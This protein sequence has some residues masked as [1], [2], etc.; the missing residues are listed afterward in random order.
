MNGRQAF[1]GLLALLVA[2]ALAILSHTEG[3][4]N[5]GPPSASDVEITPILECHR[6]RV[7]FRAAPYDGWRLT[8]RNTVTIRGDW[9]SGNS[10]TVEAEFTYEE[11]VVGGTQVTI[12]AATEISR[13][14]ECSP[15]PPTATGTPSP[16]PPTRDV[17]IP[18]MWLLKDGNGRDCIII[19]ETHPS[20]DRQRAL[21]WPDFTASNAPC[22]APVYSLHPGD[23]DGG[24]YCDKLTPHRLPLGELRR[25]AE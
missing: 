21:C 13:P 5:G 11:T 4:A 3:S 2:I 7:R 17:V 16:T 15:A 19:S 20:V 9:S 18:M 22:A 10:I 24:W 14:E 12:K 8:S 23:D 1:R 25:R 6:W